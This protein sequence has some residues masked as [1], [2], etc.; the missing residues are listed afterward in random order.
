MHNIQYASDCLSQLVGVRFPR[1]Q[2]FARTDDFLK[3]F[4]LYIHRNRFQTDS[5]HSSF[6]PNFTS[7]LNV[8]LH[9]KKRLKGINYLKL[10]LSRYTPFTFKRRYTEIV[11]G[12]TRHA[13]V[14]AGATFSRE[15][16]IGFHPDVTR[17]QVLKDVSK[18]AVSCATKVTDDSGDEASGTVNGETLQVTMN[19]TKDLEVLENARWHSMLQMFKDKMDAILI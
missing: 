16:W 2:S 14:Y 15:H 11:I 17:T 10:F 9:E 3:A 12:C 18:M 4:I 19:H 5:F 8:T 1:E 7:G 6:P 13:E